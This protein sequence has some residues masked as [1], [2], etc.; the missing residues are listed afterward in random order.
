ME[1]TSDILRYIRMIIKLY[2]KSLNSVCV[3]Y[4]LAQIETDIISF[5]ANNPGKDTVGD[6]AELRMLSKGNVS[7]GAENLIQRGLLRRDQD[8]HDRRKMHL[9]LLPAAD[10]I[11]ADIQRVRG[12]FLQQI[13]DGFEPEEMEIHSAL[14]RRILQNVRKAMEEVEKN[15]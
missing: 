10:P 5:L 13:F 1:Q 2:E 6:I 4:G 15:G 14:N 11:V 12:C 7:C 9:T 8:Q 3:R